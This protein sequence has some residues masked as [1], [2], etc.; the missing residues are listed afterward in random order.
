MMLK[1]CSKHLILE[2]KERKRVSNLKEYL[3]SEL[4]PKLGWVLPV[5]R[6]EINAKPSGVLE[7]VIHRRDCQS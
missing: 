5:L 3:R 7:M 4:G 2:L 6:T 1:P